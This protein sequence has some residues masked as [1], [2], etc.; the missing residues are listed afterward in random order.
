MAYSECLPTRLNPLAE[1]TCLFQAPASAWQP[2][3][4]L[5]VTDEMQEAHDRFLAAASR[6]G[7]PAVVSRPTEI[8]T[9]TRCE[10]LQLGP[11]ASSG[12]RCMLVVPRN[13]PPSGGSSSKPK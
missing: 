3:K 10:Q 9:A 1:R 8:G 12:R 11:I 13:E 6:S 5:A 2:D 7:W 4:L